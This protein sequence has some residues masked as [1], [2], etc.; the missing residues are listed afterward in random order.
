MVSGVRVA[1]CVCVSLDG[2]FGFSSG[3]E[4]DC[5]WGGCVKGNCGAC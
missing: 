1:L 4:A 3:C 2:L 5:G